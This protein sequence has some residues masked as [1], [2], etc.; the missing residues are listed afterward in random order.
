VQLHP[1]A[2]THLN[3]TPL[4]N[5]QLPALFKGNLNMDMTPPKIKITIKTISKPLMKGVFN[6]TFKINPKLK[7]KFALM[8]LE[9]MENWEK[10]ASE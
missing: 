6:N 4:G 2:A 3:P 7:R 9:L 5:L 8:T 10:E 1:F